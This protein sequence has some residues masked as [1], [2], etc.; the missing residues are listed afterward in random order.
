MP[1]SLVGSIRISF[2]FS[3][4]LWLATSVRLVAGPRYYGQDYAVVVGV[5][6]RLSVVT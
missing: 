3:W 6:G 5:L 1:R 4:G 2:V